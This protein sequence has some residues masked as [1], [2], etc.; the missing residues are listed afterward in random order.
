MILPYIAIALFIVGIFMIIFRQEAIQDF[1]DDIIIL[2]W[3]LKCPPS[4]FNYE[5]IRN[6]FSQVSGMSFIDEKRLDADLFIFCD[7]YREYIAKDFQ[8]FAHQYRT[9]IKRHFIDFAKRFPEMIEN[10]K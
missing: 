3:H 10:V 9:F 7:K 2:E 8:G 4:Q 6:M 1:K 5:A